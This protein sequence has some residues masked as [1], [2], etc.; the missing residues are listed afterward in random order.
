LAARAGLA[1]SS[2]TSRPLPVWAPRAPAK[3]LLPDKKAIQTKANNFKARMS[4]LLYSIF[5]Y[6]L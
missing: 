1:K 2:S 5:R 6:S 3:K 4:I